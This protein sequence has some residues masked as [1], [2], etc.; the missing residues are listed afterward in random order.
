MQVLHKLIFY[1]HVQVYSMYIYIYTHIFLI[2][3][4]LSTCIYVC[5][6][7]YGG[8][9]HHIEIHM[10]LPFLFICCV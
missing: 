5:A 1:L 9:I 4:L 2:F 7:V 3:H 6:Y 8:L 10:Y